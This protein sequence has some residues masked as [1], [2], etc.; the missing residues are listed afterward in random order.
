MTHNF[1][2]VGQP[3][4]VPVEDLEDMVK[5]GRSV[6]IPLPRGR[7][8]R[9]GLKFEWW[10]YIGPRRYRMVAHPR[11]VEQM[12]DLTERSV[13]VERESMQGQGIETPTW[14]EYV[15]TKVEAGRRKS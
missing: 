2:G 8:L 6:V 5:W 3:E 4:I 12:A 7:A 15:E 13:E 10:A 14:D 9:F 11:F 1:W